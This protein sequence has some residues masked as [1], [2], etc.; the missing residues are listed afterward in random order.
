V[1]GEHAKRFLL[2]GLLAATT[3]AGGL[4]FASEV[5]AEQPA[6]VTLC[7]AAGL[8]GTTKFVTLTI[9]QQAAFGRAGHF[10]EDGTPRAGHEADYRGACEQPGVDEVTET[11]PVCGSTT[12][13]VTTITYTYSQDEED[14]VAN[15]PVKT[16]R[17]LTAEEQA[18]LEASCTKDASIAFSDWKGEPQC[19]AKTVAET[20]TKT[21][22]SYTYNAETG[23]FVAGTPVV[24]TESRTSGVAAVKPCPPAQVASQSPVPPAPAAPTTAVAPAAAAPAPTQLPSTGTS[25]WVTALIALVTLLGG[26]GLVRLSR[27]PTD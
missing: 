25:S 9:P 6:M 14:L 15:E 21:T 13:T 26:T 20:R 7:H 2:G 8:D 4:A 5:Q 11:A 16:T 27:R 10:N 22:I 18:G 1:N 23:L 17:P 19:D 3:L 24:A 12:V